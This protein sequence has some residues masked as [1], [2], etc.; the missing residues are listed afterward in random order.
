MMMTMT[1]SKNI[2]WESDQ[3]QD[4]KIYLEKLNMNNSK[5]CL[6]I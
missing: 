2:P 1:M 5:E 3:Q 6:E 4:Y